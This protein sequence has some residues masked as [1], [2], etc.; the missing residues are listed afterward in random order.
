MFSGGIFTGTWF[1]RGLQ[2]FLF[3]DTVTGLFR[4]NSYGQEFLYFLRIPPDSSGFLFSPKAVWLRP[5]TKEGS[6]LSKIWT[7]IE[8]F[9]LSPEQDLTMA[10]VASV[11][12]WCLSA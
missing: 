9:N 2:E 11:L 5:V 8:L 12:C 1:W 4:R 7:K 3:L 10:S 6:L